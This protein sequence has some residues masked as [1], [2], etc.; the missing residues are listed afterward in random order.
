VAEAFG[1]RG[2]GGVRGQAVSLVMFFGWGSGW[3]LVQTFPRLL[4]M[5]GP[6]GTFSVYGVITLVAL[7]FVWRFVPETKG[8]TLEA[9][10]RMWAK[11]R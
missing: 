2:H 4:K 7:G 5:L 11:R 3:L 10:E 6:S 1:Y 9:I 8:L